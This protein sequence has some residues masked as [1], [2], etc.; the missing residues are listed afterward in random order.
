MDMV[1]QVSVFLENKSGRLAEVTDA[2]AAASINIG[3]LSI[4]ETSDFGIL[5]FICN[6][7]D[8]AAH[9][10]REAGF[11]VGETD[12]LAIQIPHQPGGLAKALDIIN[13]LDI[14]IEYL[15]AFANNPGQDAVVVMRVENAC[16]QEAGEALEQAGFNLLTPEEA[17]QL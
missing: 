4:A 9:V 12:V 2:I 3:A 8:E 7:P 1:Q 11:S 15:Y 10:L 14:N 16:S 17:Y 6:A 13:P 5:R